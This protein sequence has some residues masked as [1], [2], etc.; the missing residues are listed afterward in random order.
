MYLLRNLLKSTITYRSLRHRKI[1][2]LRLCIILIAEKSITMIDKNKWLM[3]GMNRL[4][5]PTALINKALKI[6][7]SEQPLCYWSLCQSIKK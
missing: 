2:V 1:E 6:K 7:S 5:P 3:G 4:H